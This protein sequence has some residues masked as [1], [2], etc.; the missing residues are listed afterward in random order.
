MGTVY[1]KV[2]TLSLDFY[3][4]AEKLTHN[5]YA[6]CYFLSCRKSSPPSPEV[7]L[8]IRFEYIPDMACFLFD[9]SPTAFICSYFLREQHISL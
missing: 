9:F 7:I 5:P 8:S 6:F 3:Q 2:I 1:T 4:R